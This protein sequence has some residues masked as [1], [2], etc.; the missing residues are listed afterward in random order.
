MTLTS[1]FV[2]TPPTA[3]QKAEEKRTINEMKEQAKKR[4][5]PESEDPEGE[6]EMESRKVAGGRVSARSI[7]ERSRD[8]AAKEGAGAVETSAMAETTTQLAAEAKKQ[9]FRTSAT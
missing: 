1:A 3:E 2:V 4:K 7:D 8:A 6:P 9:V 5:A